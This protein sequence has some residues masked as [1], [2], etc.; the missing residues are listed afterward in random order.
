[1]IEPK[2]EKIEIER[3][4]NGEWIKDFAWRMDGY[5][6]GNVEVYN[7]AMYDEEPTQAEIDAN[8][9]KWN[10]DEWRKRNGMESFIHQITPRAVKKQIGLYG[11]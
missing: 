8:R 9:K 5:E 1:M 6:N 2:V 11:N 3:S 4:Q 7:L 10:S